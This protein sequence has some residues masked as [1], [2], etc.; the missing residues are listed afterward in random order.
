MKT[1]RRGHRALL[2]PFLLVAL[3]AGLIGVP[4]AQADTPAHTD[5][6]FLFDT[7]GSMGG[8]IEEAQ[9]EV[10]EA[11]AS[12]S[13][14]LPDV[15]FGLAEVS[16]YDEVINPGFFEYGIGEGFAPWTLKVPIT[17]N[18][19]DVSSALFGLEAL[20][21]GDSPEAYGRGLYES[22]TNSAVG[23]RADAR[24]I[25]VLIADDIPHD[26][27]LNAGI[28]EQFW[29]ESPFDTGIDPGGDNTVGT[30]DDLDWQAV[31]AQ[32]VH[33]GRPLEYVD[34][35]GEPEY[36]PYWEIWAGSTG[37]S[38]LEAGGEEDLGEKLVDAVI[39]GATLPPCP[40]GVARDSHNACPTAS[41][42]S[43]PPP[44]PSNHFKI[45]PRISCAKGCT[46]VSV[47]IVFDSA[48]KV[49]TESILEEE[50]R[51]SSAR[52]NLAQASKGKAPCGKAKPKGGKA[53]KQQP[54]IKKAE[55]A[56]V[57]GP[58]TIQ[59]KLTGAG[60]KALHK[61]GKLSLKVGFTFT[62]NGGTASKST[63][64]FVVKAPAKPKGT[65]KGHRH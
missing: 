45:E 26:D 60:K 40:G 32:L 42:I 53:C 20:G 7:T 59:L 16:D 35:Q 38:V 43:S 19:A 5:V 39:S 48:G 3:C 50:G 49:L 33:D 24:G 34:Y 2:L 47:K 14:K 36:L 61:K 54:L 64:T 11:M 8:A 44:P 4:A 1:R 22:D 65:G 12:I 23:W 46:V 15:Q 21:G 27:E 51:A 30:S 31:L 37:G 41:P 57:A 28:P 52:P 29:I 9:N 58:N 6:M 62:P 56:V 63:G 18:Q 17:P 25:I 55:Q 13:S 10:Q